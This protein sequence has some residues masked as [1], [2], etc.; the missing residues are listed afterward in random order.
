MSA[1]SQ[2]A[3]AL[4]NSHAYSP[5]IFP[6]QT[7][8]PLFNEIDLQHS[9]E[10]CIF[11]S[12]LAVKFFMNLQGRPQ[13][14]KIASVG[15]STS[16]ALELLGLKVD[17]QPNENFSSDGLVN[18]F[19]IRKIAPSVALY[20]C[21]SLADDKIEKGMYKLGF[22]LTRID[23]YEPQA[24][25]KEEL[26]EFDDLIFF[27]SSAVRVMHAHYGTAVLHNKRVVAIGSST[28]CAVEKLFS[29]KSIVAKKSTAA[30]CV[31]ALVQLNN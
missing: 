30:G 31:E 27:S 13:L 9:S 21:S 25:E 15:P 14:Q 28:A 7:C 20:P 23:L 2:K 8:C 17:L 4:F 5:I 24:L 6:L 29:I 18:E 10:W 16:K 22:M 3:A 26:P 11:T 12:P 19:L 1:T